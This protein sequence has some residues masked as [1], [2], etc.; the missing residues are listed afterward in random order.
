MRSDNIKFG[1]IAG[2]FQVRAVEK[3]GSFQ[4]T[5][6]IT[7]SEAPIQWS[8]P[9]DDLDEN[10]LEELKNMLLPVTR[11]FDKKLSEIMGHFCTSRR[12]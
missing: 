1:V 12:S 9:E 8:L 3:S 5:L 7:P 6:E 10:D 4:I 11:I 2:G